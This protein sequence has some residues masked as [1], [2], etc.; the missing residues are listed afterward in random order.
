MVKRTFEHL[1]Q[2]ATDKKQRN[3][4]IE[5]LIKRRNGIDEKIDTLRVGNETESLLTTFEDA[6]QALLPFLKNNPCLQGQSEITISSETELD[7]IIN[8]EEKAELI[9]RI[10]D[11]Y[12]I[13]ITEDAEIKTFGDLVLQMERLK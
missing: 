5:K 2:R 7:F 4:E 11:Y 10:N 8:Q 1:L 3:K 6:E 12:G 13:T 9:E